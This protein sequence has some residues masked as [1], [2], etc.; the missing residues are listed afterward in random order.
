[1]DRM[2]QRR[3]NGGENRSPPSRSP[4]VAVDATTIPATRARELRDAWGDFVDGRA[5]DDSSEGAGTPQIRVPIV[6]S[7]QRSRDAG[8][9]PSGRQP[10]PSVVELPGAREL[11]LEHPLA[12]AVPLIEECMSAATVE[13]DQLTVVSDAD[14]L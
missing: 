14:G 8:V 1:M 6:D 2:T 7:W 9:D 10:A 5:L 4:W 13:A 3:A 12:R 11:W